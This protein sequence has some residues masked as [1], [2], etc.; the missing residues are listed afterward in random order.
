[1]YSLI[2]RLKDL[3]PVE[4]RDAF[5]ASSVGR[6]AV[7]ARSLAAKNA[8]FADLGV[9][10]ED[11][12][13]Y[14][15]AKVESYATSDEGI[16]PDVIEEFER[17]SQSNRVLLRDDPDTVVRIL[18][19]EVAALQQQTGSDLVSLTLQSPKLHARAKLSLSRVM[20]QTGGSVSVG[21]PAERDDDFWFA[22]MR[23]MKT[24]LQEIIQLWPVRWMTLGPKMYGNVVAPSLF[25]D[26]EAFGWMGYTDQTVAETG[27]ALAE[28]SP[29]GEG[30]Y[31]LLKREF[32]T[33][34]PHDVELCH[35]AEAH[36][37]DLGVLPLK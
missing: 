10:V 36:L 9:I 26:R 18:Q 4:S 11:T 20:S 27:D 23:M 13:A 2:A 14:I 25:T 6:M 5:I 35:K 16:P 3:P 34:Q 17:L 12:Q 33:L 37:A 32:M 15:N 24:M 1:M 30:T 8:H 31:L 19:N 22:D 29:M 28:T 7:L 21:L